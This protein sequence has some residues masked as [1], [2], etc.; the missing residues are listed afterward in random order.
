MD[1]NTNPLQAIDSTSSIAESKPHGN[2]GPGTPR[3]L[4]SGRIRRSF[5]HP[6]RL[7]GNRVQYSHPRP[8]IHQF[9]PQ[10]EGAAEDAA[11]L[12]TAPPRDISLY[13]W[14]TRSLGMGVPASGLG[15][16]KS[17]R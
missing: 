15:T 16:R 12:S 8:G 17:R 14:R 7:G 13:M 3:L 4:N 6:S 5:L 2:P 11:G 1:E 9:S 10:D